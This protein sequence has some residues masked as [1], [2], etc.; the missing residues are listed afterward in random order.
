MRIQAIEVKGED[1]KAGDLFSTAGP[2]YWDEVWAN[3]STVGE[4]VYIRTERPC[5][6]DQRDVP[7]FRIEIVNGQADGR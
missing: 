6:A 2:N 5:L 1:L 4:K 3:G 7:I